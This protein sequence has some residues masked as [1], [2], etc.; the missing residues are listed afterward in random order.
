MH[1]LLSSVSFRFWVFGK[2]PFIFLVLIYSLIP[3]WSQNTFYMISIILNALKFVLSCRIWLIWVYS[4]WAIENTVYSASIRCTLPV[5]KILVDDVELFY[6]LVIF[7]LLVLPT[8][9]RN[10]LKFSL[11]TVDISMYLCSLILFLLHIFCSSVVWCV[12]I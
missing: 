6:Y 11:T 2:F 5:T 10:V 8:V 4:S 9:G 12:H 1:G 7:H 3:L